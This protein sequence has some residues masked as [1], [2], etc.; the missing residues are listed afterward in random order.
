ML[1]AVVELRQVQIGEGDEASARFIT[2]TVIVD[3]TPDEQAE[4]LASLADLPGPAVAT[5]S[6][7][8]FAQQLAELGK[9]SE[10]EA[11]AW[12][13]RGEPPAALETAIDKLPAEERFAARMLLSSAT[14]YEFGH[15]LCPKLGAL[16][17]FD[18]LARRDLWMA[19]ALL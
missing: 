13:A 8:Q 1:R 5:I 3:M 16:L 11:L 15:P 19:A 9:I 18:E 12:A 4:H 17:G 10:A 6:D 2:E 14:K 7:R